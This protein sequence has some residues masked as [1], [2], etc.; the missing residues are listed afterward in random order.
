MN[1]I[2][3]FECDLVQRVPPMPSRTKTQ[4]VRCGATLFRTNADS[5]NRTLAWTI[6]GLVLYSVALT[7]PFLAMKSGSITQK[8]DL[9]TGV[10]QLYKHGIIPLATLVLLTCVLIPLIQML[11]LL[12]IFVPFKMNRQ[13]KYVIPVFHL[14]NHIS[15]WSMMEIYLIGILVSIV[16][17]GNMAT[18][19]PGLG[20]IAFGM[21]VFV[22]TFAISSVDVRMV[23]ERIGRGQ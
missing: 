22:L 19:V 10:Q 12:Y 8:T 4:C 3:C 11:S 21:L 5:I 9:L 7:F 17:L 14:F 6:A 1:E 16:K 23:W 15:P 18:V 20:V 2:A 13:A